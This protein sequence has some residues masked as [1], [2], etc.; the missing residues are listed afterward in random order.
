HEAIHQDRTIHGKV[1][2]VHISIALK[3]RRRH[4]VRARRLQFEERELSPFIIRVKNGR[5]LVVEAVNIILVAVVA[6]VPSVSLSIWIEH[7]EVV[8]EGAVF[9]EHEDDMIEG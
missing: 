6:D 5:E 9:L 4:V 1:E 3:P 7:A 2:A 8:I